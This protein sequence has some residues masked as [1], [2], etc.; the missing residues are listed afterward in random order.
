MAYR[1]SV[2]IR[3][4][5]RNGH[6]WADRYPFIVEA[7]NQLR[8]PALPIGSVA[9]LGILSEQRVTRTRMRRM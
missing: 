7:V 6:D 4:L 1:D 5:P 8:A 2:G 9:T 3:L